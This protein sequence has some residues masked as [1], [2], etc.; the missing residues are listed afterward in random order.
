MSTIRGE[1]HCAFGFDEV[2]S[3]YEVA[4]GAAE[5]IESPYCDDVTGADALKE[6]LQLRS[7]LVCSGCDL[8][9]DTETAGGC[10]CVSL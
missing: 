5:S 8:F 4:Q 7:V 10:Q 3:F 9:P 6:Q 2:D 1:P